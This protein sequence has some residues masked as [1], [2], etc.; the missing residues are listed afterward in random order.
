ME[1][2][3]TLILNDKK[4]PNFK[5]ILNLKNYES[6]AIKF[7][8]ILDKN[9]N[10][11]LCIK[12]KHSVIKVPLNLVQGK[13]EFLLPK[14]INLE[15]NL[16]CAVVDVSN[17]FCPEIVLSGSLNNA[18]ENTK[19]E[20]AFVQEKPKDVSTLYVQDEDEQLEKLIDKNLEEDNNTVYYDNCSACKYRKA[21]YESGE[22]VCCGGNQLVNS[23][24]E[25]NNIDSE[26]NKENQNLIECAVEGSVE[27]DKSVNDIIDEQSFYKQIKSQIDTLFN[28]Y[29]RDLLLERIIPNS[30]WVKV[31]YNNNQEYYVIGLIYDN[32]EEPSY[33]SYGIPSED[34][35]N[36]PEDLKEF[37]QWLPIDFNNPL[38]EGYWIVY[39]DA[40]KGKTLKI[41]FV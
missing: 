8:N 13:G 40:K 14:G 33:I 37:A 36:P 29:E 26:E 9:K 30:K 35:N 39:Q 24:S 12:Q 7:F 28:R 1:N 27:E 18:L 10:Y 4:N 5:A 20:Q 23:E 31:D 17:A 38:K 41:D 22:C 25:K 11:A 19:I 16:L 21:F 2:A 32:G 3:K 6:C 34:S 15:E